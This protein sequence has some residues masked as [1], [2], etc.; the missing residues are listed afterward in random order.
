MARAAR[1]SLS[2]ASVAA[3]VWMICVATRLFA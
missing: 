3:F 2:L 1:D